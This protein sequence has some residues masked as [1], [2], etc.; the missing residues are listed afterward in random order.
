MLIIEIALGVALGLA[1]FYV[2]RPYWIGIF[3]G[4]FVLILLISI[5]LLVWLC[6]IFWNVISSLLPFF[7]IFLCS[8][9]FV[10]Y[11]DKKNAKKTVFLLELNRETQLDYHTNALFDLLEKLLFNNFSNLNKSKIIFEYENDYFSSDIEIIKFPFRNIDKDDFYVTIKN[12]NDKSQIT[13]NCK[14]KYVSV[15]D[16]SF[17]KT[18]DGYINY[19][20]FVKSLFIELDKKFIYIK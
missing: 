10:H 9:I 11:I 15:T 12:K 13:L 18:R 16:T 19:S 17:H 1:F 7:I 14:Y 8:L 6:Y 5:P 2:L 3:S 4:F 20:N